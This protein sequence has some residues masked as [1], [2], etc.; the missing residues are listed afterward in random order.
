[1]PDQQVPLF[2]TPIALADTVAHLPNIHFG[3]FSNQWVITWFVRVLLGTYLGENEPD[4]FV[5][6]NRLSGSKPGTL[7]N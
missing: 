2:M 7:S 5:V 4:Q 6:R 3:R 1:M